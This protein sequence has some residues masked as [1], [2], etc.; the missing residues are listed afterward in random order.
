MTQETLKLANEITAEIEK[1]EI[2]ISNYNILN[3]HYIAFI[4]KRW[5]I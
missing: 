4:C 3:P 5:D 2:H 1:L